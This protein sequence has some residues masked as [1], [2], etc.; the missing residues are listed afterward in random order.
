M[1]AIENLRTDRQEVQGEA[2]IFPTK[3]ALPA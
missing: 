2:G 3:W 1:V